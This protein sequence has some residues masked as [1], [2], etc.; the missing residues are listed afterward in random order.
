MSIYKQYHFVKGEK[1]SNNKISRL[2][3]DIDQYFEPIILLQ[4][5]K[6]KKTQEEKEVDPDNV[7]CVKTFK[8][9]VS[10]I[11]KETIV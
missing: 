11:N 8:V 2:P 5:K 9:L 1:Y 10:I 7:K 6:S 3:K 4:N